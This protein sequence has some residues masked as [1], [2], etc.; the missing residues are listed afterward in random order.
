MIASYCRHQEISVSQVTLK[1]STRGADVH[2][3]PKWDRSVWT[4]TARRWGRLADNH[5]HWKFPAERLSV[6]RMKSVPT[7][8]AGRQ[9]STQGRFGFRQRTY[10]AELVINEAGDKQLRVVVA[11]HHGGLLIRGQA[12]TPVSHVERL[13]THPTHLENIVFT[14]PGRRSLMHLHAPC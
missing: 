4:G 2:G 1:I 14:R 3:R 11:D 6:G 12:H 10:P 13:H 7:S 9:I 8:S 5:I